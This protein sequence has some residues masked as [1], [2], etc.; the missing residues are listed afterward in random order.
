M[1]LGKMVEIP[2]AMLTPILCSQEVHISNIMLTNFAKS[3]CL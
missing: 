3:V 2:A 1:E